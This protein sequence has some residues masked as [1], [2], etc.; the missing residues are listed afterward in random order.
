MIKLEQDKMTAAIERA[1]AV[2][3]RVTVIDADNRVY[4]VTG[5]KGAL[6][7]VRFKV[8]D[9]QRFGSCEC[10]AGQRGKLCYHLA[11]AAAVNLGVQAMRRSAPVVERRVE[12]GHRGERV[13]VVRCKGWTI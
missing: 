5:S 1:K 11:A 8:I 4:C 12:Y 13:T 3:P 10:E 2:R 6:Y 7:T 9:G